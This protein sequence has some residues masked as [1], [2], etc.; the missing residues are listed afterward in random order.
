MKKILTVAAIIVS[1]GLLVAG[2]MNNGGSP[3]KKSGSPLDGASCL[4]CHT[5]SI[6]EV[7]WISTN[8]PE[9]G[10]VPGEIYTITLSA[11]HATAQKLGFELT[12]ENSSEKTGSFTVTDGDRTRLAFSDKSITHKPA[13]V[14]PTDQA[15]SWQMQW[16]A[17]DVDKGEITFYAAIN[18]ANGNG[19]TSGDTIFTSSL[20]FVQDATTTNIIEYENEGFKVYPNP[21]SNFINVKTSETPHYISLSNLNGQ[22]I[23]NF[24]TNNKTI[25][26]YNIDDIPKGLYLIEAKGNE[27]QWVQKIQIE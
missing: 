3:G 25:N 5:G 22:H 1:A 9:S 10:W 14:I 19:S 15:I 11:S 13:G 24:E 4:Q 20:S 6:S 16:T 27:K 18:A 7:D 21:A 12:A 26:T 23:K 2:T 8:I 17:P